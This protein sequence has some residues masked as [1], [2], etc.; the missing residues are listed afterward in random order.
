MKIENKSKSAKFDNETSIHL[1]FYGLDPRVE[2][3]RCGKTLVTLSTPNSQSGITFA[4]RV[5]NG[6]N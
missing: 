2:I 1:V 6:L 3:R 5:Y 4:N